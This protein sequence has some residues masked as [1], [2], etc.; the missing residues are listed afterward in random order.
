MLNVL[1]IVRRTLRSE[2]NMKKEARHLFTKAIDSLI[3]GIEL[4][5]RPSNVG[6][7]HAVLILIDHSFEMLLKASIIERGGKITQDGKAETI[8]MGQCIR[9]CLSNEKIK[10]L[11][12][13]EVLV[14]QTLNSLRDAAQHYIIDLSEQQLYFHAQSGLTLFRDIAKNVFEVDLET[15]LPERVLPLST[16]PPLEITAFFQ[17]EILEIEKLLSPNSRK[18]VEAKEKLRALAIF[19]HSI[20]GNELQPTDGE[21]K[22][23]LDQI[24]EKQSF[25]EIFPS[26]SAI[27]FTT[28]GYGPS[29]DLRIT[30]KEDAT[31]ITIVPEGTPGISVVAIKRVNELDFYSMNLT[32]L[33]QK[34]GINTTKLLTVIRELKIQEDID[35]FK[36]IRIKKS[37]HKMYSMKALDTLKKSIP[38]LDLEDVWKRNRTP[39]KGKK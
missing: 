18:I 34:V 37:I 1:I 32:D 23:V 12:A 31:P 38:S 19:E 14:L 5:N 7:T 15:R 29:I 33:S 36:E 8:G 4:F 2:V 20:Q 25:D 21:L 24:R 27:Q 39:Y 22:K 3:L 9:Q 13:E 16:I 35:C 30:K 10:F 28:N 26:V 17:S 6:R 11:S